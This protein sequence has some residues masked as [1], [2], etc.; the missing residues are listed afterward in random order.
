MWRAVGSCGLVL[1]VHA[2]FDFTAFKC[3]LCH[4]RG[5]LEAALGQAGSEGRDKGSS[6]PNQ[7]MEGGS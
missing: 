4:A 5:E 2:Q 1:L 7:G 3:R 6:P